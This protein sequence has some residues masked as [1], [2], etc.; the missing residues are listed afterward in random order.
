[1]ARLSPFQRRQQKRR[2]RVTVLALGLAGFALASCDTNGALE[3][4]KSF[5]ETAGKTI[6][7]ALGLNEETPYERLPAEDVKLADATRQKALETKRDGEASAWRNVKT[8]N[9]G[10]VT[11]VR[12]F[13]TEAGVFCREYKE[14]VSIGVEKDEAVNTG[15]RTDGKS[16]AAAS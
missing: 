6:D 14:V 1:M 11:P 9:S 12:T 5:F 15:C 4:T 13:V 3:S 2:R 16:W 10:S 8:G 7:E